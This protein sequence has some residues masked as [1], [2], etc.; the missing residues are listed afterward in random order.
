MDDTFESEI[1][2]LD[3]GTK[4]LARK[5]FIDTATTLQGNSGSAGN[6][7]ALASNSLDGLDEWG[8]DFVLSSADA[9]LLKLNETVSNTDNVATLFGDILENYFSSTIDPLLQSSLQSLLKELPSVPAID[10]AVAPTAGVSY[11]SDD[12]LSLEITQQL[13]ECTALREKRACNEAKPKLEQIWMRLNSLSSS[14]SWMPSIQLACLGAL[15]LLEIG[16][17]AKDQKDL[18]RAMLSFQQ[19]LN[20]LQSQR[21]SVSHDAFTDTEDLN[22]ILCSLH[23]ELGVVYE[24]AGQPANSWSSFSAHLRLI[25]KMRPAK[26]DWGIFGDSCFHLATILKNGD[27]L[28]LAEEY[29][30]RAAAAASKADDGILKTKCSALLA[31]I[32]QL[33][34]SGNKV[35]KPVH[36]RTLSTN[37][38]RSLS[39]SSAM[40]EANLDLPAPSPL[41]VAPMHEESSDDED[42]AK[43]FEPMPGQSGSDLGE[44]FAGSDITSIMQ[45]RKVLAGGDGGVEK[46]V[47]EEDNVHTEQS[48]IDYIS[49]S[50]EFNDDDNNYPPSQL[51]VGH[52][53]PPPIKV[54]KSGSDMRVWLESIMDIVAP[55]MGYHLAAVTSEVAEVENMSKEVEKAEFLSYTWALAYY[56]WARK[57]CRLGYIAACRGAIFTFFICLSSLVSSSSGTTMS[58]DNRFHVFAIC[59]QLI[60]LFCKIR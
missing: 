52:V 29:V 56:K 12:P 10:L 40:I 28:R 30:S 41:A 21:D 37:R 32:L 42:W 59:K 22:V 17:N 5:L 8:D 38:S 20:Q 11:Q 3:I 43:E 46:K 19:A 47:S 53:F 44:M 36:R 7:S 27:S 34:S 58:D 1:S 4:P 18:E 49:T 45:M 31:E 51:S 48:L 23:Y 35:K 57:F 9:P 50:E 26:I 14:T 60:F 55:Q 16:R 33:N 13:G 25:P 15:C 2:G 24:Q 39:G 54:P 6:S